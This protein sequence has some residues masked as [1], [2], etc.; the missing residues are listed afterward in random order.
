VD[1]AIA[2]VNE[3]VPPLPSSVSPALAALIMDLLEKNPKRRPNSALELEGIL[4]QLRLPTK[5]ERVARER[6]APETIPPKRTGHAPER[7]MPPSIAPAR[8]RP[9]PDAPSIR[10]T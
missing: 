9:R 5:A 7:A 3:P 4:K 6:G 8:Y 1:I 2:Q 10:H